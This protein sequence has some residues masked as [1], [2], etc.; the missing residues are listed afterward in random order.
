MANFDLTIFCFFEVLWDSTFFLEVL[1]DFLD[2]GDVAEYCK[3]DSL[4][5][6]LILGDFSFFPDG[7]FVL[8]ET[9]WLSDFSLPMIMKYY[10]CQIYEHWYNVS[11]E[12]H[13]AQVYL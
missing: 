2:K 8:E 3:Q 11:E 13:H 6:F 5:V 9:F 10:L 12:Q 1:V 4:N 7:D